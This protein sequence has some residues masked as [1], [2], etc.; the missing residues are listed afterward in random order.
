MQDYL[1]SEGLGANAP[2]IA[3]ESK[4]IN[5]ELFIMILQLVL[6]QY[7]KDLEDI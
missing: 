6:M 2:T 7:M 5:I 4:V 3:S 1:L